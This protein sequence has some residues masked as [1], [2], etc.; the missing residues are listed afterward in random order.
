MIY[1]PVLYYYYVYSSATVPSTVPPVPCTRSDEFGPDFCKTDSRI[2]LTPFELLIKVNSLRP[3]SFPALVHQQIRGLR[4]NPCFGDPC[5][6]MVVE[7]VPLPVCYGKGGEM[8]L[9]H[10]P[11]MVHD[12]TAQIVY[13]LQS[14]LSGGTRN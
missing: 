5:D 8:T 7:M 4:S 3:L 14:A 12:D 6:F 11:P 9:V 1:Y 10:R 13:L 2:A